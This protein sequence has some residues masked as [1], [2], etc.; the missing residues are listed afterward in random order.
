MQPAAQLAKDLHAQPAAGATLSPLSTS[1]Y[2]FCVYLYAYLSTPHRG[3]EI[4]VV[5]SPAL[6]AVAAV[7]TTSFRV[8]LDNGR[9]LFEIFF[10]QKEVQL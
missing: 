5:R 8:P 1:L 2:V 6:A 7:E 9:R 4:G 3:S 10:G